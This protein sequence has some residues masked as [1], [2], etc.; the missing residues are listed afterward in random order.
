MVL[1]SFCSQVSK[2]MDASVNGKTV[3]GSVQVEHTI[4]GIVPVQ[5]RLNRRC[6][7]LFHSTKL[8]LLVET[9]PL[10]IYE[11]SIDTKMTTSIRTSKTFTIVVIM[12]FK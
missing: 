1:L 8:A 2:W 9:G 11:N 5:T 10:K 12:I 6:L 7:A 4:V 3:G